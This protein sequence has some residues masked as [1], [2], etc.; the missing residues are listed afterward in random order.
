VFKEAQR[1]WDSG[2]AK[3]WFEAMEML[4]LGK[5]SR[6]CCTDEGHTELERGILTDK[7]EECWRI[8]HEMASGS[9][10]VVDLHAL[11]VVASQFLGL[12]V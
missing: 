5:C 1:G 8:G 9:G 10:H 6:N 4:N 7:V 12:A 11:H 3:F 2:R